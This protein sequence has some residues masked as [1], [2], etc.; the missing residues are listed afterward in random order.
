MAT[1]PTPPSGESDHYR[2]ADLPFGVLRVSPQLPLALRVLR[3]RRPVNEDYA[4]IYGLRTVVLR[5]SCI[6]GTRQLGWRIRLGGVVPGRHAPHSTDHPYGDGK[7]VR[8][9]LF[10][11]DLVGSRARGRADRPRFGRGVQR[12]WRPANQLSLL[13]CLGRSEV[14]GKEPAISFAPWRPGDQRVFI[15]DVRRASDLVG[16]QPKTGVAAASPRSTSGQAR[17][18]TCWP[19]FYQTS[20]G[21]P[22]SGKELRNDRQARAALLAASIIQG[23]AACARRRLPATAP[24]ISLG[25]LRAGPHPI[26]GCAPYGTTAW[27]ELPEA[28]YVRIGPRHHAPLRIRRCLPTRESLPGSPTL[29]AGW[30]FSITTC[31]WAGLRRMELRPGVW[32]PRA[33]P[34]AIRAPAPVASSR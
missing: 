22:G 14:T 9:L 25:I 4:R 5:Q 12:G 13:Q 17:I 1:W 33:A 27:R 29:T 21:R 19:A 18:A 15:A 2:L 30:A 6:Y 23:M 10:V 8:D 32:R 24:P 26:R 16:W 31:Y 3:E 11:D 34:E 20:P 28:K 7:Q